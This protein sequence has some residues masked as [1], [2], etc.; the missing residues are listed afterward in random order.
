[1]KISSTKRNIILGLFVDDILVAFNESDRSE[2]ESAK[3]LLKAQYELTDMG[4]AHH[5]LGMRLTRGSR[6]EMYI[7]QYTYVK[8]K[9]KQFNMSEC[10]EL[11]TPESLQRLS[12]ITAEVGRSSGEVNPHQYREIV[13]S[14]MYAA[15][16]TRP[17]I[18][19]STNI[20]SRF[21]VNP[22]NNHLVAAKRVLR[23][24]KGASNY[25]LVYRG[26]HELGVGDEN[27]HSIT[28]KI[29]TGDMVNI[30]RS[31]LEQK[32][33]GN[34]SYMRPLEVLAYCDA[35]WGGDLLDRK[36][37]T[38]YCIFINN[39]LVSWNVKKQPTVALST[40]EAEL[41]SIVEVIKEV[42]WVR[43]LLVE[44]SYPLQEPIVT[45]SD[46]QSALDVVENDCLHDR[47]KH[48]EIKY[49]FVRDETRKGR[50]LLEWISTQDQI[51]DIFTKGLGPTLFSKF[52]S[53]LIT[54]ITIK[55]EC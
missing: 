19:H 1:M 33:A 6:G 4:P 26:S 12:K 14:L 44:L 52:R 13:G 8:E 30:S 3:S 29:I 42:I 10:R 20:L 17:D 41:M 46:N 53:K 39:N 18:A 31:E 51:A 15:M 36:S 49:H 47:S 25:G 55:E 5:I 21:M 38:G 24:L 50:V 2:W 11:S 40:A 32:K 23:Y 28:N 45:Y 9:L 37:T 22:D 16:S 48:I 34:N 54:R 35:D 27:N 43:K 7:D